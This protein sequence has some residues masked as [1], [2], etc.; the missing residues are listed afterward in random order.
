MPSEE[1]HWVTAQDYIGKLARNKR[2]GI[3]YRV[4]P[5]MRGSVESEES[6]RLV[7]LGGK[8]TV[9]RR[10]VARFEDA[11]IVSVPESQ[12]AKLSI[13]PGYKA[14]MKFTE[15]FVSGVRIEFEEPLHVEA[16]DHFRLTYN[17]LTH[18]V[19]V[20]RICTQTA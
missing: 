10:R 1:K 14:T 18:A 17:V 16:G 5:Y 9:P 6:V 12:E 4:L 11:Y 3:L 15:M 13:T 19:D 8:G 20:K 7:R 2:S